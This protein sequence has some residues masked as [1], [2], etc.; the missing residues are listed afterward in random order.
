MSFVD[1]EMLDEFKKLSIVLEGA[2]MQEN[3]TLTVAKVEAMK[4]P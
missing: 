2:E 3:L 1:I 4:I